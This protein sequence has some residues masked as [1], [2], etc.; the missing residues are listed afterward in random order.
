MTR[1]TFYQ[2][3]LERQHLCKLTTK[4]QT[5]IVI[6]THKATLPPLIPANVLTVPENQRAAKAKVTL[7]QMH[8]LADASIQE[9]SYLTRL[10]GVKAANRIL[11]KGNPEI[12]E[13]PGLVHLPH[14]QVKG[15]RARL[16]WIPLLAL[17]FPL[18]IPHA[19]T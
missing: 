11:E 9:K 14:P 16:F 19:R 4:L 3:L 5:T 10:Q 15:A 13:S 6:S 8:L 18:I 12:Q 7:V 17:F 2:K 1:M